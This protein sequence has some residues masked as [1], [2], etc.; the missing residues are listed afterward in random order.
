MKFMCAYTWRCLGPNFTSC[1]DLHYD[2]ATFSGFCLLLFCSPAFL[3]TCSPEPLSC[4]LWPYYAG[5]S[6]CWLKCLPKLCICL[7]FTFLED[8]GCKERLWAALWTG[9]LHPVS[10]LSLIHSY[11][12]SINASPLLY[13]Q[14]CCH[15]YLGNL[16][17]VVTI[18]ISSSA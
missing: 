18:N 10:L 11:L 9:A 2:S 3:L 14:L 13:D 17:N 8:F 5:C 6:A 15:I 12:L 16:P 1:S 4:G 7:F